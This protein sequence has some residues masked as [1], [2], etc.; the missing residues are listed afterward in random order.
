MVPKNLFSRL[1]GFDEA[2][3]P[4]YGEDSDLAF[5]VKETGRKVFYQPMAEVIHFEGIS[6]G[7]DLT[8]GTK[9]FQVANGQKFYQRWHS[10]LSSHRSPGSNLRFERE[11]RVR[12]RIL[13]VDACTPTPDQD[14]GS[15]KIFNFYTN[16][17]GAILQG[18]VCPG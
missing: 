8:R 12:K 17:S 4:A 11:R 2:Y 14:S 16:F 13:V 18:D 3:A 1:G 7:T 6:S 10:V 9:S 15:F 5:K